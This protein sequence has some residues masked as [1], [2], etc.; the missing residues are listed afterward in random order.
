[1]QDE[2]QNGAQVGQIRRH[3]QIVG[4]ECGGIE[5]KPSRQIGTHGAV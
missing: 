1:M 5:L 2:N 4:D 3:N